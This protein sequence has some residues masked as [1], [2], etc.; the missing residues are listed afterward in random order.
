MGYLPYL[1][2]FDIALVI[3]SHFGLEDYSIGG[4]EGLVMET[5]GAVVFTLHG[6]FYS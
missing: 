2:T 6:I 1:S 3:P 4:Q 5:R